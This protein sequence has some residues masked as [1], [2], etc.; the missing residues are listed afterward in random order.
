MQP[1]LKKQANGLKATIEAKTPVKK[2][3]KL[4]KN[5]L[6]PQPTIKTAV[7]AVAKAA[8]V[9]AFKNLKLEGKE[10]PV[11]PKKAPAKKTATK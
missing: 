6:N 1:K 2:T 3:V 10:K 4:A 5:D 9:S 7:A 8:P 11:T